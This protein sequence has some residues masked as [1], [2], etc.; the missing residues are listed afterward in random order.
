VIHAAFSSRIH[1]FPFIPLGVVSRGQVRPRPQP[2]TELEYWMNQ[3]S[4]A[5]MARA[6][7]TRGNEQDGSSPVARWNFH[8][9]DQSVEMSSP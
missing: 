7:Q 8:R 3:I 4:R 2:G 6:A 1:H 9:P 5:A